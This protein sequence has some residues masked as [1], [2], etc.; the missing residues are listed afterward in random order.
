MHWIVDVRAADIAP[1]VQLD[2]NPQVVP[3][4]QLAPN[5]TFHAVFPNER[6]GD[7]GKVLSAEGDR[8][9]IE[10]N[11]GRGRWNVRRATGEV[12][13]PVPG[14]TPWLLESRVA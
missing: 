4:A 11:G 7:G 5:D 14:S 1:N 3:G 6:R 8:A 13:P 9:V 10:F 12:I 2:F